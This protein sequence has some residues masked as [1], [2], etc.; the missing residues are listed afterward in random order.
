MA[1]WGSHLDEVDDGLGEEVLEQRHELVSNEGLR[2]LQQSL[3]GG[4]QGEAA[5]QLP[6]PCLAGP[7]SSAAVCCATE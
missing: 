3:V 7:H 5:S 2:M 6:Q 1:P 4:L